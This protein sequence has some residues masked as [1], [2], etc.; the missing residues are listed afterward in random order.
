MR[1]LRYQEALTHHPDIDPIRVSVRDLSERFEAGNS[2]AA[3]LRAMGPFNP[4]ED[5]FKFENDFAI[6]AEQAV[7]FF[8]MLTD[9]L[10]EGVVEHVLDRYVNVLRG[11]DLN[12]LPKFEGRLPNEVIDFVT[13]R[14][15][16]QLASRIF[17][18]F[19]DPQGSDYGR[20]GGMAFAGYDFYLAGRPIDTSVTAPPAVGPLGDYIYERLL[21]SLRLNLGTF[22]EWVVDL[23]LLA[24]M[25]EIA[26]AALG[27]AIG[28]VG[29]TIGAAIGAFLGGRV[30][31]FDLGR[32]PEVLL[33]PTKREWELLKDILDRQAA[34]PVGLIYGDKPSLWDQHQVL[35]IGYTDDRAGRGTLVIWDNEDGPKSATMRLDF[36]EDELQ[37]TGSDPTVK[38]FFHESYT[39]KRPPK[40][41]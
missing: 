2:V 20:C 37:V 7:D 10:V 6:T 13:G 3:L 28:A 12:P 39:P 29:G 18:S 16:P 36:R 34:C 33:D 35:A 5:A 25:D 4:E 1:L 19:V 15:R 38:G 41:L 26:T 11:I 8:N 24:G 14:I 27:A 9:K 32:G 23:H 40:G 31:I 21:D 22:V 30:D 17:D